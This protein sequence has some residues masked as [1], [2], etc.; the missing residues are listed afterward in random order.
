M[1]YHNYES[2]LRELDVGI[3]ALPISYFVQ[4][5]DGHFCQDGQTGI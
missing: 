5:P 1:Y 3:E 4:T 2:L